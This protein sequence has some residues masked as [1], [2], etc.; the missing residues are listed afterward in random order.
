M[1]TMETTRVHEYSFTRFLCP[2]IPLETE[3]LLTRLFTRNHFDVQR[4]DDD[5]NQW[6]YKNIHNMARRVLHTTYTTSG[7]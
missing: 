2:M 7:H 3:V 4:L 6:K 1:H 5:R